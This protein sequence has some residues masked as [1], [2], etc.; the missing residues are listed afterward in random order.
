MDRWMVTMTGIVMAAATRTGTTPRLIW[1][2]VQ[3]H[4]RGKKGSRG[5]FDC[6]KSRLYEDLTEFHQLEERIRSLWGVTTS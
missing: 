4:V 6:R 5:G 1:N 3:E 2:F